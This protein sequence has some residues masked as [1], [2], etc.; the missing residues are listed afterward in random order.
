M[1]SRIVFVGTLLAGLCASAAVPTVSNVT[2]TQDARRKV[3]VTYTLSGEAGIVTLTAQT[4]R[5]DN[6]W[7][8]VDDAALTFVAGDVNKV[9]EPGDRS[10]TWLPHKSW[11]DHFIVGGNIRIGVKAWAKSAPPDYMVVSLVSSKDVRF[12][13]SAAAVP[14]GVQDDR[15]KTDY[16]AFRKIRA[17]GVRWR[18]G[19]PE[20]P[21]EVGRNSTTEVPHEV[22]LDYDYYIGIYPVTQGHWE[23]VNG[24]R[25]SYFQSADY[26]MRPVENVCWGEIRGN[27]GDGYNWP[28][29]GHAV[30]YWSFMGNLRARTGINTFDLPTESQWEYAARAGCGSAYYDGTEP[31]LNAKDKDGNPI[32]DGTSANL[33]RLGRV[34]WNGG[35]PGGNGVVPAATC[36]ASEGG[37][38]IVGSYEPNAWGLYDML[39]TAWEWCLDWSANA[40]TYGING[41]MTGNNRVLRGGTWCNSTSAKGRCANRAGDKPTSKF[42]DYTC[43]VVCPAVVE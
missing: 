33:A 5:G 13:T 3:T 26:K 43:R 34:W 30:V 20:K 31:E 22:E 12:Y 27:A 14:G 36:L 25:P 41:P 15:Y 21:A 2:T 9:V 23:R 28:S 8:D 19:S 17:A 10:L 18:M 7:I 4:N 35:M 24:T 40:T 6:V 1:N 38:P 11:P 39:G 32:N 42:K 29:N 37:T 16:M